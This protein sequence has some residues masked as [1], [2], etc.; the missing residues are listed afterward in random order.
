MVLIPPV[1][2]TTLLKNAVEATGVGAIEMLG[3]TAVVAEVDS[4]PLA[5]AR[6]NAVNS[7]SVMTAGASLL[8]GAAGLTAI[9]T[10][11]LKL[12]VCAKPLWENITAVSAAIPIG[13]AFNLNFGFIKISG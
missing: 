4:E 7:E 2:V 8:L 5:V 3:E 10:G 6:A 12:A 1:V 11:V 13:I 9:R